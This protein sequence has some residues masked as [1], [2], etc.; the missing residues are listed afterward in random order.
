MLLKAFNISTGE[1]Y[2]VD[3]KEVSELELNPNIILESVDSYEVIA[4]F[5]GSTQWTFVNNPETSEVS[6]LSKERELESLLT[7]V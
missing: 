2:F 3:N 6:E 7:L 4:P 1:S 5:L